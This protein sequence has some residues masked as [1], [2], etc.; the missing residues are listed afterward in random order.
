MVHRIDGKPVYGHNGFWGT[1]AWYSPETGTVAAGATLHR[2]CYAELVPIVQ[3]ATTET[4]G[5]ERRP[6]R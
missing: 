6:A 4:G 3:K 5:Q 1:A 2:D